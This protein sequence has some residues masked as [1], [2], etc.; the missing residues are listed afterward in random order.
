MENGCFTALITP[1]TADE[2]LDTEG[3][4]RLI[5]F[6]VK[7]GITGILAAGTTGESPTL[8][9]E[10]HHKAVTEIAKKTG[11]SCMC[12][13]GAG[14]NN[15]SEAMEAAAHAVQENVD[16]VLL[17]D[18]YYNGPSSLEIRK[19][20][21]EPI[22]EKFGGTEIIPY[23]I[24]GRTGAQLLPE[25]LAA[26]TERFG[27]INSVK[28]ATGNP[29]N[30][31]H[32]RKLCG[33]D[34]TIFSGDDGLIFDI[35]T[36][37]AIKAGGGISVMSNIIPAPLTRMIRHLNNGEEQRAAE[38]HDAVKPLLSLVTVTTEEETRFGPAK[39]RARN[40]LPLKTLMRILG[41]PSGGCRQPVGRMTKAGLDTVVSAARSVQENNPE[42][43]AP[44]AD[45][46]GVDIE[47]RLNNPVYLEGLYYS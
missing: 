20:Y 23:I 47:E 8:K 34:F 38:I 9:W 15:T 27:N 30:M 24:P 26:L 3:L 29:E 28:E 12:I 13:A 42:I 39:C 36:D 40:P 46:F 10:E 1:F 22:A 37:S 33:N 31:K 16:A 35:M 19:E 17:V 32:T 14:S 41:M 45:F 21:Y 6:Q 11:D 25:D 7:N 18:P 43:F 4:D 2:R 44:I 5:E